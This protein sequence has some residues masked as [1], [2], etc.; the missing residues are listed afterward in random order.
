[1]DLGLT[2]WDFWLDNL[3]WCVTVWR[4]RLPS[5]SRVSGDRSRVIMRPGRSRSRALS[6]GQTPVRGAA[7]SQERRSCDRD[8]WVTAC[9][10][11]SWHLT[12]TSETSEHCVSAFCVTCRSHPPHRQ[13]FK[14][15]RLVRPQDGGESQNTDKLGKTFSKGRMF[16]AQLCWYFRPELIIR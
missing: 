14:V 13:N 16:S 4:S 8:P 10:D 6:R 11:M 2:Y 15:S 7:R 5:V 3:F 12:D 1:M 9:L